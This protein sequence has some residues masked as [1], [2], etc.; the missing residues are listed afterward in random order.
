MNTDQGQR[1]RGGVARLRYPE[2]PGEGAEL[3]SMICEER[4]GNVRGC[5]GVMRHEGGHEGAVRGS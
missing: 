1:R 2:P 5:E 3:G 4:E